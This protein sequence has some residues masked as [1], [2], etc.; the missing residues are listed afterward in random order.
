MEKT[1]QMYE[2][3]A[4][5]VFAT[6]N[7]DYCIVSYK[8]D[9]TAFNGVKRGTIAGKGAIN[10]QMSNTLMQML[11]ENGVP[12]HFVRQLSEQP[13]RSIAYVSC[14]PATLAR[15]I[16]RFEETGTY[17]PTRITPVDLFPQTFHVETVCLLTHKD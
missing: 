5:K 16:A 1:T 11:A 12:T 3:K 14:D 13:A 2:G 4:K 8:D 10:N 9:A 17:T 15:D 7:P 6:D